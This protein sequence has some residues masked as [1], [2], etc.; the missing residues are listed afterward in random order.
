ARVTL[1]HTTDLHG[2]LTPWDYLEDRP[3]VRGLTKVATLVRAIREEGPPTVLLDAGDCIQGGIEFGRVG[4]KPGPDPMMA[5][6]SR[7]GYDAMALGNH[8]FDFGLSELVEAR[9]AATFPWLSANLVREA[10]GQ[11]AFAASW[12]GAPGGVRVG[13]VGLTTP[14]IPFLA[15]TGNASGLPVLPPV[16]SARREVERLRS[17]GRCDVVVLLAHSG[18]ERDP[19]TGAEREGGAPFANWG[20]R[21]A[22]EVPGVDVVILGHTHEVVPSVRVGGALVTQAGKWAQQLGRVDLV[23]TRGSATERWKL[24]SASARMIAVTDSLPEDE[25]IA[26]LAK[27]H[28][29]AARTALGQTLCNAT[30]EI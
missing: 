18:L 4:R 12:I 13:V 19:E 21:L 5:A 30:R 16:E 14:A 26:A 23:L 25:E 24:T 2:A 1:L 6:M 17:S 29:E 28:H 9:K 10:D 3:A 8:E 7:M 11:P 20:Y 22:T 27:P 15:D